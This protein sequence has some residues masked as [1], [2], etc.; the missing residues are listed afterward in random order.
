MPAK[1]MP[2]SNVW[3]WRGIISTEVEVQGAKRDLH[4]GSYGGVA[5]NPLHALAI[6]ISRLKD[7]EGHIHIPGLF[8]KLGQP[9]RGPKK[10]SGI[11]IHYISTRR[12]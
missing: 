1:D 12:Y 10:S 8:D 9:D 7:A 5:P 11:M 3:P 2:A 6:I 4:S